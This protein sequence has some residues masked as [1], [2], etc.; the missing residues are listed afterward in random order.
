LTDVLTFVEE[1]IVRMRYIIDIAGMDKPVTGRAIEEW[2]G[3]V[4]GWSR[5][6]SGG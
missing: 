6:E 3:E 1:G 2:I 4:N 5:K